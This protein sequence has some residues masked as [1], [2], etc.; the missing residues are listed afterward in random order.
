MID[1]LGNIA[2]GFDW[3]RDHATPV[4]AQLTFSKDRAITEALQAVQPLWTKDEIARRCVIVRCVGS[5][6]EELFV[7]GQVVLKMWPPEYTQQWHDDRVVI[8]CTQK[9]K[10]IQAVKL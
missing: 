7:D 10:R 8:T 9:F 6:A 4:Q 3:L 2:A 1:P 5:E